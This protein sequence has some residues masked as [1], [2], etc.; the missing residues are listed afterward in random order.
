MAALEHRIGRLVFDLA[1][2]D[3]AARGGF[4]ALLRNRF[5]SMILP[6]LQAAL[7]RID[8][9]GKLIRFDRVEIDL[10]VFA[11]DELDDD[12]LTRRLLEQL[13]AALVP[14]APADDAPPDTDELLAFL[15]SGEL[16]W[17]EPGKAL[18]ILCTNLLALDSHSLRRMAER[19]RPLLIG[20]STAERLVRQLPAT[21]VRRLFRALLPDALELP[22]AAAFGEDTMASA[23][24]LASVPDSLL[25]TLAE[26]IRRL[27]GG[28]RLPE[29]GEVVSLYVALGSRIPLAPQS[30]V[31]TLAPTPLATAEPAMHATP[32]PVHAAGAVL[33]HPFLAMFFDGLGLLAGPGRFRDHDAHC[34]AV[35]LAHHLATGAEDAPEPETLLF[36]LLCGLPFSEPLPRRIELSEHERKEVDSLLRSVIGHWKRL[37]NTSP[38]GLR[39]GFLSRPGRLERRGDAWLLSLQSS[40]IDIL[41]QD[42]PW[43]LSRVRTPFMQSILSVDW[44]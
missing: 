14:P 30:A 43:T 36:K 39:E 37:G 24:S 10:G 42:L 38:A 18:A 12:E 13:S 7:D 19:L 17:V 9:P 34:R 44:R 4:E 33:L 11:P 41:L 16:P 21:L 29:L 25:A 2:P 27:A 32:R 22:L 28:L 8:R 3:R 35:L 26:M 31:L 40:G 5:D 1:A 15:Q 23:A 6:A 20:R